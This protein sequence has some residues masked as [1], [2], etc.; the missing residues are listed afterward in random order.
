MTLAVQAQEF[1]D[2]HSEAKFK[3][4]AEAF[5]ALDDELQVAVT[6]LKQAKH[7]QEV[8][9]LFETE[10]N[11]S[12]EPWEDVSGRYKLVVQRYAFE[13][14]WNYSK[15]SVYR[16]GELIAEVHRN[17]GAFPHLFIEGH[18]NG[19][20][21]LVCGED[22]QGQTVIELDTGQ[23]RD[24]LPTSGTLGF[25]FCWAGY[26]W[27]ASMQ[28][29]LVEG[30]IWACP[31]EFRLY[32]FADPMNGWAEL[33]VEVNGK[34]GY[35]DTSERKPEFEGGTVKCF[36]L[37]DDD[38][39]D[40]DEEETD[41]KDRPVAAYRI[42]KRE[43]PKLVMTE[44]WVSEAE[45]ERRA[46]RLKAQQEYEAWRADFKANDPLYLKYRELVQHPALSPEDYESW[47]VTFEG[48]APNF[49]E[50]ETRFCRRIVKRSD[51]QP[52]TI[53]LEWGTKTGPIK[54]AIYK[55]GKTQDAKYF[56]HSAAQMESAFCI[57]RELVAS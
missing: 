49:T 50:R 39:D 44:D 29:L 46:K 12:G 42:F 54:L 18:P 41:P 3:E 5:D 48:W 24:F 23:R 36:Q 55:D 40:D 43:G 32:D 14:G 35:I 31:Y 51:D 21:Y 4:F 15:G 7:R 28:V 1:L 16:D 8:I 34:A 19:H 37:S 27:V 52:Y 11:P 38:D 45:Q 13:K 33:E 17:Y 20:D 2:R 22:Y 47:G 6:E 9:K 25:G 26:E 30:C 10:G 57:A 56:E 53:D